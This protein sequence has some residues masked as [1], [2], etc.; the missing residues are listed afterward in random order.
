M[1]NKK[2]CYAILMLTAVAV[3]ILSFAALPIHAATTGNAMT[4]V[5]DTN[6][7]GATGGLDTVTLP[8]PLETLPTP[9]T[10]AATLPDSGIGVPGTTSV[11][12]GT[13][14]ANPD[15]GDDGLGWVGVIIVVAVVAAIIIVVVSMMPRKK[16]Y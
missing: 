1:M 15:T 16:E 6:I 2:T 8:A 9:G 12:P 4:N 14:A 13:T 11:V 3:S 5:P 7:G 10:S